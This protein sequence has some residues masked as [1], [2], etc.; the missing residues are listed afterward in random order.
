MLNVPDVSTT[1]RCHV[2]RWT[3]GLVQ[4][5]DAGSCDGGNCVSSCHQA[6]D[7]LKGVSTI[8]SDRANPGAPPPRGLIWRG[9][10]LKEDG[11][12]FESLVSVERRLAF[13]YLQGFFDF[14]SPEAW[15]LSEDADVLQAHTMACVGDV[16]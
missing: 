4:S 5:H 16:L 9:E 1:S 10:E 15:L 8:T 3:G 6:E 2:H 12:E 14:A 7:G 13:V 11:V